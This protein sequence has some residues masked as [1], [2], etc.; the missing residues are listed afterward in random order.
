MRLAPP[1]QVMRFKPSTAAL[2]SAVPLEQALD[3]SLLLWRREKL[4]SMLSVLSV[5]VWL[6]SLSLFGQE[7]SRKL[8][9]KVEARKEAVFVV[10]KYRIAMRWEMEMRSVIMQPPRQAACMDV[11]RRRSPKAD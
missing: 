9:V 4:L 7:I 11:D 10:Y 1:P 8:V 2:T 5:P 6:H 3:I